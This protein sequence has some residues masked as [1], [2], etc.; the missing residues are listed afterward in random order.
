MKLVLVAPCSFD[1]IKAWILDP[2]KTMAVTCGTVMMAF[3]K[4]PSPEPTAVSGP[5]LPVN[6]AP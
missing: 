5:E 6:F 2:V 1:P 4:L 3:L